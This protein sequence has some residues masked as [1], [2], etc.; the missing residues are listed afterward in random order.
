MGTRTFLMAVAGESF[1]NADG[2]SRQ[3]IIA[4]CAVGEPIVFVRE[5]G[6][7]YDRYA[8]KVVRERT[9]EC[10]G[11]V[12]NRQSKDMR[13]MLRRMEV[14]SAEIA[15]L[16]GGGWLFKRQ[17]GIVLCVRVETG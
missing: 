5:V 1:A 17:R 6:N 3:R 16:T 9:G 8:V 11:Y 12:P 4:R 15:K 13:G 7:P 14:R 2:T 10:L